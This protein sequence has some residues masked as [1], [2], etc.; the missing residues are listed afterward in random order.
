MSV[1]TWDW[2]ALP[3]GITTASQLP[4][5]AKPELF[6]PAS[7]EF[8]ARDYQNDAKDGVWREWDSGKRATLGVMATGG[9]KTLVFGMVAKEAIEEKGGR[10]L[11]LAHRE[12]LLEQAQEKLAFVGVH[13]VIEKADQKARKAIQEASRSYLDHR[14]IK[15]VVGSVQSLRGARLESWPR[16]YFQYVVCDEAHHSAAS[17]YANIFRHFAGAKF[18]GVTA[19][20]FRADKQNIGSFYESVAFNYPL[21]WMIENKW[22]APITWS[23]SDVRIDLRAV[24]ITAGDLNQGDLEDAIKPFIQDM[25]RAIKWKKDGSPHLGDRRA[26]LF[27]PAR[28]SVDVAIRPAEM[29]AEGLVKVGIPAKAIWGDHPNR[30]AI[31]RAF[32]A[33][34]FQVLC[35]TPNLLGEGVDFPFIEAAILACPTKSAGL[36]AQMIGRTTRLSPETGKVDALCV[37][38][39]WLIDKHKLATPFN[40]IRPEGDEDEARVAAEII[41]SGKESDIIKAA[42]M[43]AA[44]VAEERKRKAEEEA[45]KRKEAEDLRKQQKRERDERVRQRMI[46]KPINLRVKDGSSNLGFRQF[47]PFSVKTTAIAGIT[48]QSRGEP[49]TQAQ[50]RKLTEDWKVP[51]D[52][53]AGLT[54]ESANELLAFCFNRYRQGLAPM[55]MVKKLM[56]LGVDVNK[57]LGFRQGQGW[58][59]MRSLEKRRSG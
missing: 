29:F 15:C 39:D 11:I 21:P 7:V 49:L 25:A 55:W 56:A 45:R 6:V 57:A 31:V 37:D 10:V 27:S 9:G 28:K 26:I 3:P 54:K 2:T 58:A 40:L 43:A 13:S 38:F 16:D 1:A 46:Q 12:E 14:D 23:K 47:N 20:P 32:R 48:T 4:E 59:V 24:K 53:V 18:L 50:H 19:T 22:L 42:D 41:A 17:S 36:F 33:G 52:E 44:Q 5:V 8:R 30:V 34:E 35:G 51:H